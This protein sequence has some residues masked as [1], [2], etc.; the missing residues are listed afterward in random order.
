MNTQQSQHPH[1]VLT[2]A[3]GPVLPAAPTGHSPAVVAIMWA[4]VGAFCSGG[5]AVLGFLLGAAQSS[6]CSGMFCGLEEV[7]AGALIGW[8]LGSVFAIAASVSNGGGTGVDKT[9]RAV[10]A[11]LGIVALPAVLLLPALI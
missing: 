5:G 3:E 8:G 11:I 4:I 6:P 10:S 7:L 9:A 1:A 2:A